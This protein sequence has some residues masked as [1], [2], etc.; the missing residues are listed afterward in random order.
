M[1]IIEQFIDTFFVQYGDADFG[2][3]QHVVIVVL[4]LGWLKVSAAELIESTK[5]RLHLNGTAVI[6][7][8]QQ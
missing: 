7:C 1:E 5:K 3:D 2:R 8:L 4:Q 6:W